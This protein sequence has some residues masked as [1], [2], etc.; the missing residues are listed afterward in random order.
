MKEQLLSQISLMKEEVESKLT[1]LSNPADV[2]SFKVQYLGK[3]GLV[4]EL[5]K[6]LGSLSS[7]DRPVVGK[8]INQLKVYV[9]TNCSELL[10]KL[11]DEAVSEKMETEKVDISLPPRSL[12]AGKIH[13]ITKVMNELIDVFT[14]MGFSV[15]EGPEVEIDYY[16][17]EALNFLKDH[18]ARDMQDTF[19][20]E[21]NRLLRTHTSPVQVRVMEKKKP[22][23]FMI[24]P[25][26]VYRRDTPDLT[27]SPVFHQVEGLMVDQRI[28][29][30]DLKG[31]LTEFVH[32][33]FGEKTNVRFRPSFFPFTEP[34]AELEI[35]CV[36]CRGTGCRVCKNTGWIEILGCGMVDPAVFESV[37]YNPQEVTGFAFGMGV[38]RI[39]M[40]K[41]N[42]DDI[43]LFYENNIRFLDQF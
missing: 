25:G 19:F 24:S 9:D 7:E 36:M 16:N 39:A 5:L 23:V 35:E 10:A 6:Q 3:K 33:V 37:G 40:L 32:N 17:F 21:G 43:R 18:P 1:G 31:V 29:F 13:P 12:P 22:P 27:H 42:I 26:V 2:K 30:G 28:T 41:Y 11:E 38:E 4:T 8:E 15:F 20:I 34:S 14:S